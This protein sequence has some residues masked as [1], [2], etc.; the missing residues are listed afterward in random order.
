MINMKVGPVNG[1]EIV[2][3]GLD[4]VAKYTPDILQGQANI[5]GK[6][7]VE[8]A[9]SYL[10]TPGPRGKKWKPIK[11][12]T[13]E[14]RLVNR[15]KNPLLDTGEMR[16]SIAIVKRGNMSVVVAATNWKAPIHEN[17]C[18]IRNIPRRQFMQPAADEV[19]NNKSFNRQLDIFIR[20]KVKGLY[21]G[22]GYV[23]PFFQDRYSLPKQSSIQKTDRP[24]RRK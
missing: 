9:R 23:K 13:L 6:M 17:G 15:N 8:K 19:A 11:K 14:R 24:R 5:I 4:N 22:Q 12:E 21:E 3:R 20:Q 18:R 1:V 10:G 7:I 2:V 16:D